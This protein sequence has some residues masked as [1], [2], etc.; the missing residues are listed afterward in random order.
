MSRK[1]RPIAALIVAALAF[2]IPALASDAPKTFTAKGIACN[3]ADA[4]GELTRLAAE[5]KRKV[6]DAYALVRIVHG[7]CIELSS[8][9]TIEGADESNIA[10]CVRPAG[11]ASCWWMSPEMVS[12]LTPEGL[13][14][15]LKQ[16]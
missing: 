15:A 5:N 14:D 9:V 7:E 2:V 10:I 4:I 11:E 8:T 3:N 16:P 13:R 12:G 1:S 6:F